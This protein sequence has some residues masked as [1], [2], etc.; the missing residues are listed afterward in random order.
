MLTEVKNYQA[1]PV[2]TVHN[3]VG[4]P[5]KISRKQLVEMVLL[6]LCN[7]KTTLE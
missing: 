4:Y 7:L 5:P 1:T 3:P 6:I 2:I